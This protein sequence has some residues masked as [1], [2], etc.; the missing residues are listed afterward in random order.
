[1]EPVETELM[2]LEFM[3][4]SKNKSHKTK[5]NL[6]SKGKGN[7]KEEDTFDQKN[8]KTPKE[9]GVNNS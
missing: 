7:F 4:G 2:D 1:M 5:K 8:E 3:I 6:K 9:Q